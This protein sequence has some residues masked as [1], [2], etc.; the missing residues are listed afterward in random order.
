MLRH[1]PLKNAK[2]RPKGR[3]FAFLFHVE[4]FKKRN[5]SQDALAEY[6]H[7]KAKDTILAVP[8]IFFGNS[9]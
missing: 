6:T 3:H 9:P 5:R 1:I 2:G 7:F 4:H 8:K